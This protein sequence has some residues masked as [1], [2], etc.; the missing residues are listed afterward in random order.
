MIIAVIENQSQLLN[1]LLTSRQSQVTRPF[2]GQEGEHAE[3]KQRAYESVGYGGESRLATGRESL[4]WFDGAVF[5]RLG[6]PERCG[7]CA[8]FQRL[9]IVP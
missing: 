3:G 2:G 4:R 1:H 5:A 6:S 9:M 7:Q 8:D